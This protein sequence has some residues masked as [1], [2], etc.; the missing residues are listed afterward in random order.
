MCFAGAARQHEGMSVLAII[1]AG[2]WGTALSVVLAPRFKRIRLWVWEADL[3]SRMAEKRE[4]DLYLPG[5]R[6]PDNVEP[7]NDLPAAL[8]QAEWV[9][10][11]TPSQHLRR[12]VEEAGAWLD[13]EAPVISA[14]KGFEGSTLLRMSEVLHEVLSRRFPP[15]I[16][17]LS[18][19]SFAREVAAGLPTAVTIASKEN[20]LAQQIQQRFSGPTL[21]LY[22]SE[23]PIGVE[24]GGALKNV[25]AIAAGICEGLG[26][27]TNARA[28]LITRGLAEITRLAV[29]MGGKAQTLSGLSGLGD[30][31]LTCTGDLSRNRRLGIELASGKALQDILSSS[32][33]VAEGVP[34]TFAALHLARKFAIQLPITEQMAA[35]LRGQKTP[36]E[37]LRDLMERSLKEETA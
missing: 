35:I 6:I 36:L 21:R 33:M 7:L 29:A 3:A 10:M 19:P 17:V 12:V 13:P 20:G 24:V 23:D 25:I 2:S 8:G 34:T 31:A 32:P 18:G 37:A 1:G 14:T 26:L 11:V 27:G 16:A 28:A 22:A 30:L 5:F 4:N 9:L 15:R